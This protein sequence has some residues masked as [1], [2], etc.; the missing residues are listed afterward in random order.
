[1]FMFYSFRSLLSSWSTE[2]GLK[3]QFTVQA[4][5]IGSINGLTHSADM[6]PLCQCRCMCTYVRARDCV[7]GCVCGCVCVCVHFYVHGKRT[8]NSFFLLHLCSMHTWFT[9]TAIYTYKHGY[10]IKLQLCK[11]YSF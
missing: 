4:F 10:Y 11:R 5:N 7:C 6:W 8:R 1:M 3:L 2:S 9:L